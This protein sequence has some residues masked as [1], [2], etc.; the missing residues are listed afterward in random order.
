M[1]PTKVVVKVVLIY[2]EQLETW[3][4]VNDQNVFDF[5]VA[6]FMNEYTVSE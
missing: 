1:M 3:N 4:V 5:K 2:S 6:Q